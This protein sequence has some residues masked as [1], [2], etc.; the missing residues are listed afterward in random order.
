MHES[1]KFE[2]LDKSNL[3]SVVAPAFSNHGKLE[4]GIDPGWS[5]W[6]STLNGSPTLP[7]LL[8][9]QTALITAPVD[10]FSAITLVST[11]SFTDIS[12]DFA[13][14]SKNTTILNFNQL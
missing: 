10:A 5:P 6:L 8:S 14:T 2:R 3:N 9:N 1:L 4:S 11:A 12:N 13:S 7:G